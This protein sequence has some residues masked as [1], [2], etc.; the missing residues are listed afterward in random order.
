MI[1]PILASQENVLP[2]WSHEYLAFALL[3]VV[4]VAA[5]IFDI[6]TTRIPTKMLYTS[7]ILGFLLAAATGLAHDGWSGLTLHLGLAGLAFFS[8]AIPFFLIFHA[9]ALGG[10]DVK[11]MAAVGAI[12]ASWEV[13]VGTAMYGFIAAMI[14]AFA[15]MIKNKIVG[16]TLKRVATA[17]LLTATTK[18]KPNL[19][20]DTPRIPLAVGFCIG[21]VI[22]SLEFLLHIRM[23]WS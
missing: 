12:S 2:W 23:P 13:V 7:I 22:A 10:G 21:G 20:T 4:L 19:D 6:C 14:I 17:A 1:H 9:G 8:A 18:V 15:V 11:L 5:A 3:A 16:R